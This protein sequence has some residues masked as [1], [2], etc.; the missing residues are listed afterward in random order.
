MHAGK[1]RG[2]ELFQKQELIES[3]NDL[4]QQ[5]KK[6]YQMILDDEIEAD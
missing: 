4:H 3:M 6:R 5:M 1:F 2:A